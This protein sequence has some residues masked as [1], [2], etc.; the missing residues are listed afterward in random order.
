MDTGIQQL[1]KLISKYGIS[2]NPT[3]NEFQSS[4]RLFFN[5]PRLHAL[6][7]PYCMHK[8][9]E[10]LQRGDSIVLHRFYLAYNEKS[11]RLAFFMVRDDG[12]IIEKVVFLRHHRYQMASKA[13][14]SH[15]HRL[16]TNTAIAA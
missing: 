10:E 1:N 14:A 15:V 16:L 11:P 2:P 8:V 4:M 5:D 6:R 12:T 9:V 7:L 3:H 13:L